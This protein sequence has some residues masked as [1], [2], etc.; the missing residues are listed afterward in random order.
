M[1]MTSSSSP[2]HSDRSVDLMASAGREGGVKFHEVVRGSD[3]LKYTGS[4]PMCSDDDNNNDDDNSVIITCL[5]FDSVGRLYAGGGDGRLRV[6]IFDNDN[7]DKEV[8][9]LTTLIPS[10]VKP[11]SSSSLSSL[12]KWKRGELDSAKY[13]SPILAMNILESLNLIANRNGK[14]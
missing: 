11:S 7:S 4:V 2:V 6:T 14:C 1:A 13:L 8:G 12:W 9:M 5:K 3:E 10:Q